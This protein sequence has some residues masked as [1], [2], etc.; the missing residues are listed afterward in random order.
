[1]SCLHIPLPYAPVIPETHTQTRSRW[2]G[3]AVPS[4]SAPYHHRQLTNNAPAGTVID[5]SR[6]QLSVTL[7]LHHMGCR[8]ESVR[9]TSYISN[10]Y[11]YMRS[12]VGIATRYG[13]DGPGIESRWAA[14]FSALAETGPAAHPI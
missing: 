9:C 11:L 8:Y 6:H 3:L 10:S 12:V 14:R 4:T 1:M 5:H 13:L 2:R 7:K